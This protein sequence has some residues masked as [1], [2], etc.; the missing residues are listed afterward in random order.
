MDPVKVDDAGTR[1][2]EAAIRPIE[3]V[4]KKLWEHGEQ[5]KM[6]PEMT[7][8]VT[9]IPERERLQKEVERTTKEVEDSP[10]FEVDPALWNNMIKAEEALEKFDAGLKKNMGGGD[11]G[12]PEFMANDPE[13]V[14]WRG[15]LM[16]PDMTKKIAGEPELA[17]PG[18]EAPKVLKTTDYERYDEASNSWVDD[19]EQQQKIDEWDRMQNP[20]NAVDERGFADRGTEL[21]TFMANDSES[22]KWRND[23]REGKMSPQGSQ[24]TTSEATGWDFIS[25]KF[26]KLIAIAEKQLG[27]DPV[28]LQEA[29]LGR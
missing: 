9:G 19:F 18:V 7:E 4:V 25:E 11:F 8:K 20:L 21:P 28:M 22:V 23:V 13:S 5:L 24:V 3:A 15:D 26:D 14:K 17:Q 6:S 29:G 2:G 10:T 1:F 27:K 12:A 16:N